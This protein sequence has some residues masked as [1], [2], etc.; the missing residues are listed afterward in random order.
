MPNYAVLDDNNVVVNRIVADSL[1]IAQEATGLVCILCDGNSAIND[2]WNG[3][4]FVK[5]VFEAPVVEEP[6]VE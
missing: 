5:P 4:E 6:E 3:T 1:E 2:T